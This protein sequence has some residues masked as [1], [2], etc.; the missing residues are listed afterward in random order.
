MPD[1]ADPRLHLNRNAVDIPL[2]LETDWFTIKLCDQHDHDE[3]K[4]LRRRAGDDIAEIAPAGGDM[5]KVRVNSGTRHSIMSAIHDNHLV[6]GG[7]CHHVFAADKDRTSRYYQTDEMVLRFN[8]KATTADIQNTLNEYK[9]RLLRKYPYTKDTYLV[10]ITRDSALRTRPRN[11]EDPL[12]APGPIAIASELSTERKDILEYAEAD[13]V[14]RAQAFGQITD[15]LFDQQWHLRSM[16][17]PDLAQDASISACDAWEQLKEPGDPKVVV[18]VLD[19]G[20]D[21]D[22]PDFRRK[23]KIVHPK[24]FVD[25]D[26]RPFAET[27]YDNYHGTPCAGLA[28]ADMNGEGVVGVAPNCSF[29]PVRISFKANT[30]QLWNIFDHAS[31]YARVISCSWGPPPVKSALPKLISDQFDHIAENGGPDGKGC[32]IVFSAGNYNTPLVSEGKFYRWVDHENSNLMSHEILNG[33][34]SHN[35]VV[36]VSSCTSLNKKALYSNWGDHIS[37]CAPSN[38][39]HPLD[40]F[41]YLPGRGVWTTDNEKVGSGVTAGSRYTGQFGGTSSSAP[42]VAGVAALVISANRDLSAAEV[43]ELLEDTADRIVD[44]TVDPMLNHNFGKY[45]K[46]ENGKLHS[47]WFGHGRVNASQAVK[48]AKAYKRK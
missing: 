22:H 19:D 13:L 33:F 31:R 7:I 15:S 1:Q 18:A 8:D 29:M 12:S 42:L 38:N 36:A 9:L 4:A 2:A 45:E 25:G 14:E 30:D 34:A 10:Q 11:P 40:R 46:R 24:D 16:E 37:V 23:G 6:N 44:E 39:R 26:A 48:A 21:L 41:A 28:I 3:L 27:Q 47:K 20:F 17:G 35:G 5:T 32:V 43:K